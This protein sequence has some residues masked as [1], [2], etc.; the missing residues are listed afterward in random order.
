MGIGFGDIT[1][2]PNRYAYLASH[3]AESAEFIFGMNAIFYDNLPDEWRKKRPLKTNTMRKIRYK[4]PHNSM[5]SSATA[6]KKSLASS[7][8]IHHLHLSEPAKYKNPP[9]N[10]A[11][12]SILQCVPN[13]WD[14]LAFWESTAFG[15]GNLFYNWYQAAKK[16]PESAEWNGYDAIFLSWKNFPEYFFYFPTDTNI[17]ADAHVIP[18]PEFSPDEL[19][20]QQKWDVCDNQ[21]A[22]ASNKR[23]AD[24][25]GDWGEFNQEYPIDDSVAFKFTGM[26]WFNPDALSMIREYICPPIARGSLVFDNTEDPTVHWAEDKAGYILIWEWPQDDVFY[27]IAIDTGGGVGGDYTVLWVLRPAE[28]AGEQHKLIAK[29]KSNRIGA[30]DAGVL[31]WKLGYL[32][33][34]A[35][36]VVEKQNQGIHT[37]DTMAKGGGIPQ[38]SNGYPHMFMHTSFDRATQKKTLRFGWN[39]GTHVAKELMLGHAQRIVNEGSLWVP[40]A[41]TLIE[42]EGFAFDT[43]KNDWIQK[44][45]DPKTHLSHDD[46]IMT[47]SMALQGVI[48]GRDQAALSRM[49]DG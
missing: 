4:A 12:T 41:E 47:I 8:L 18:K 46:E 22:W 1:W 10:D 36:A 40:S 25:H 15:M 48:Q 20:F 24:C 6:N 3:E 2:R 7:Q 35:Y 38:M 31:G 28:K 13:H 42:M 32:Y 30:H 37:I 39:T 49:K 14:T 43:E 34:R 19:E 44:V 9:A 29:V 45:T 27:I 5:F 26:Q 16:G 11:V 21:M 17:P 33:N 23:R